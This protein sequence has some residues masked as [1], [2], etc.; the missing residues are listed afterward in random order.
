MAYPQIQ[1]EFLNYLKAYS[2]LGTRPP[3]SA[4]SH[5]ED[6][7]TGSPRRAQS[8]LQVSFPLEMP[9]P[10]H[11][12]PKSPLYT[13]RHFISENQEAF[14]C[15]VHSLF[16]TSAHLWNNLVCP[17]ELKRLS[18]SQCSTQRHIDEGFQVLELHG[19]ESLHVPLSGETPESGE[20]SGSRP[21]PSSPAENA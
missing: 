8:Q 6:Q 2:A 3:L 19:K 5:F 18:T 11:L 1:E 15:E 16:P 12:V 17:T 20:R 13:E 4:L 9:S 7:A 10:S 14:P 21:I